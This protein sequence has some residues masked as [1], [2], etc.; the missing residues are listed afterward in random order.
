M[1]TKEMR[2]AVCKPGYWW[3]NRA[4]L[5]EAPDW[6]EAPMPPNYSVND[7]TLFGYSQ[8]EFLTKQYR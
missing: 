5:G 7:Y 6:H 3:E 8:R 1:T 4:P 2:R